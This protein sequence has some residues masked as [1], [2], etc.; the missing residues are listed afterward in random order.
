VDSVDKAVK[1]HTQFEREIRSIFVVSGKT[2]E[3]LEALFNFDI[4]K[5]TMFAARTIAPLC[6]KTLSRCHEGIS[7]VHGT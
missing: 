2:G 5:A 7:T 4:R 1:I 3:N 6:G